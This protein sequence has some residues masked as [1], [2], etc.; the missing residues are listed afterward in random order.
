MIDEP[1]LRA[2]GEFLVPQHVWR[3]LCRLNVWIDPV[4]VSEWIALMQGYAGAQGRG[5]SHDSLA[6]ALRWLDPERDTRLSRE[7]AV[8]LMDEGTRLS[9]VWTGARLTRDRLDVEHC[10]PFSAWPCSDLW[11]LLPATR[12]VNQRQKRDRLVTSRRLLD[13]RERILRW[14]EQAWLAAGSEA[15]RQRFFEEARASLPLCLEDVPEPGSEQVLE[16]MQ[17]RRGFLSQ[18]QRLPEW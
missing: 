17:L 18:T 12:T 16:G 13:A 2:F 3:S 7:R 5:F 10:F 14:W 8:A 4:L 1:F 9:C 15:W 6:G 11:N